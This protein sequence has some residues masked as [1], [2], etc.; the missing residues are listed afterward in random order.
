MLALTVLP[1]L[2]RADAL[3]LAS[4]ECVS[5]EGKGIPAG[6]QIDG[7]RVKTFSG[8]ALLLFRSPVK[9]S[10]GTILLFPGG[11]Y[12][13]LEMQKEG[14]NTA[15]FLNQL[16]FDVALLEYHVASG[17]KTRDLALADAMTAF[18]LLKNN[19][20]AL[21]LHAGRFGIMGYS[22]GGHLAAR[23]VQN[24]AANE[25]P[26]D[27][28]LVYPAYLNEGAPG[29]DIPDIKPPQKSGRLLVVISSNDNP[30]WV[31]SSQA[32]AESWKALGGAVT[33]HFLPDGGHGF[34]MEADSSASAQH[35]ADLLK[36]FL[37]DKSGAASNHLNRASVL[38]RTLVDVD[39][40][41]IPALEDY[42]V[43]WNAPSKNSGESMPCGGGDIGLNVWVENGDLLIYLSRSG[44]FDENNVFPKLGRLRVTL[45][46]N[47]F[48]DGG[49]F[50]Q[51]LKLREGFVEITGEKD[52]IKAKI[53]VWV[54]VFRP[55]AH[56]NIESSQPTS[57][58]AA[59]EN[60]R[61]AD[62]ELTNLE[63][64]ASRSWV[65]APQKAVVHPDQVGFQGVEVRFLHRN[66]DF[67]VFDLCVKQQELEAV[68]SRLWNPLAG[69]TF[70]GAFS[71]SN[72]IPA[73][74]REGRYASTDF[75]AWVLR[76][77]VP[78]RNH[79]L[80]AVLHVENTKTVS[81][82]D[83]GLKKI[84]RNANA[85]RAT[86]RAKSEQWW[87]GFWE[88]SHVFI[89]VEKPDPA[90]GPWQ[91]GRNYQVFRYQLG[92][93][94]YGKY[95]TKFNGGLFTYD[96]EYVDTN[97]PF[98]PD[99]R[100]WG[101]GSF[102]AQN[103]RLVYWPM[104][105]S[106]DFDL[107]KAQFDFYQ[108]ALGNAELRSEVYWGIKAASFT[109]QIENFGLP[110]AFEYGWN[111]KPSAEKGVEDNDWLGYLWD[112]SLEFCQM[113][114][115]QRK[116]NGQNVKIHLPLIESCLGFF[117]DYYQK[118]ATAVTGK[119][120]SADGKLILFP[121]SGCETYKMALN[122]SS[123]IA[124]LRSVLGSLIALPESDLSPA[125][126]EKWQN[127]LSRVPEIAFRD[128]NGF[129]TIS[130]AWKWERIQNC[131]L[132]QLYP[133]YPWGLYGIGKPDLDVAINTWKYGTD[134]LDQKRISSWHQ[135]AIFC[136]RLGLTDEAANLTLQKMGDSGRR[137]PTWWGPGHDWV[138]DHNWGGSGMIGVQEMLMQTVDDKIYLLPAW[139][140]TWDVNFKLHAPGNTIVECVYRDGKVVKLGITPKIRAKDVIL[141]VL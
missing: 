8:P 38:A 100:Q 128:M 97:K 84:Q 49:T 114:L 23:T 110:V 113:I 139:P 12:N 83:S 65:G 93:N 135:D 133:V 22:A 96:P 134:L 79:T 4:I 24:L 46:P 18:R 82:W 129:K 48:A 104:L 70:G 13:I 88:R 30:D 105:K 28:I 111:R 127:M 27:L 132:P 121:G 120:L 66:R 98:S 19:A 108:R 6:N 136:A 112:T 126:R 5:L 16:G 67:T 73:G 140:K 75:K 103:Q 15:R 87:S 1:F 42:N 7:D 91:V 59:Y 21:K 76:S 52:G 26:D 25:Q 14:E 115:D 102:T 141:P 118:K 31:K 57:V 2:A 55:V 117:D 99:H 101:G 119:P 69:L 50:R 11:G 124:A 72:M 106:D 32:Y 62:R 61:L 41:S 138:P 95:P 17:S 64:D 68:K 107:M 125:Q 81:D 36:A 137:F 94:A 20:S 63:C 9:S 86:A 85:A 71:G 60:W 37:L 51:E 45:S 29:I 35:W 39:H 131:E 122:S 44:A 58:T 89:N 33:L 130:P 77:K 54:D 43:V 40:P 123:T 80:Q 53:A 34:G 47:P 74:T 90:S 116:Y 78:A 92:C 3:S 56:I 10:L 109:E